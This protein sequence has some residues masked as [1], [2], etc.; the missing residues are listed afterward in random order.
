MGRKLMIFE[1]TPAQLEYLKN[2][3]PLLKQAIESIG[4][5]EREMEPD[6]Y[7]GVIK[8]IV[9]QQIST[10]ATKTIWA[11]I[12]ALV[13]MPT[14]GSIAHLSPKAL[15]ACGLSWRKV[16]YILEF[17]QAVVD[18]EIDLDDLKG[19]DNEV[20]IK[21]LMKIKGIGRWTAQMI[22]IFT[23][24]RMNVISFDDLGIMRGLKNLYHQET[25]SKDQLVQIQQRYSPYESI[26]SLYLW[27]LSRQVFVS[28]KKTQV[29]V[30]EQAVYSSPLGNI[31]ITFQ[32]NVV[33]AIKWTQASP[34]GSKNEL[35]ELVARQLEE[36]FSGGRT[37]FDFPYRLVG[38]SFQLQV[39]RQLEKIPYGMTCSY[40]DIAVAI[41][42][43][44]AT[45]AVG[46]ANN[47]N[48][49]A[50]VV[51]CHR[52]IGAN[53]KLVGY[54]AGLAIKAQ[55]LT[56]EATNLSKRGCNE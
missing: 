53:K 7:L 15:Q 4:M 29:K 6:L 25:F 12:N 19:R 44:K 10:Q 17:S 22:L 52:V 42:N 40:K 23:L 43:E 30:S 1:Y 37:R 14:A 38:T 47:K 24:G 33:L 55:L 3:E 18:Q 8:Q 48:P 11:K 54:A 26:A 27:E 32:D 45:R 34:G 36:Y 16:N 13:E 49:M 31:A 20:F 51:P 35:T 5:I 28:S 21:E 41:G 39:W 46:G 56:L 2:R 9:S 50:I